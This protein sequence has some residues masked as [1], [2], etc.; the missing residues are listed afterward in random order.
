MYLVASFITVRIAITLKG[1]LPFNIQK[2]F[3][4]H[5]GKNA[6]WYYYAQGISAS[7]L[8]TIIDLFSG[9][10]WVWRWAMM[11]GINL[12]VTIVIAECMSIVYSFIGKI[13]MKLCQEWKLKHI[14]QNFYRWT[15]G[16]MEQMT[17]NAELLLNSER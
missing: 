5:I 2:S 8:Y 9:I 1:R 13:R 3:I 14:Y 17:R 16:D 7:L 6:I 12:I 15:G 4:G 11:F 10:Y